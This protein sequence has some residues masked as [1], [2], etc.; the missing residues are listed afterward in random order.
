MNKTFDSSSYIMNIHPDFYNKYKTITSS[1]N[2]KVVNLFW[3]DNE[4]I[5]MLNDSKVEDFKYELKKIRQLL[6]L[7]FLGFFL[8]GLLTVFCA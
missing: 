1:L 4:E 2:G 8:L 3:A 5:K 7:C 6:L